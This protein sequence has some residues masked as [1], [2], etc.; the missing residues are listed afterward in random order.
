[1]KTD[2]IPA[3]GKLMPD[4]TP[5][6]T[7]A[8]VKPYGPNPGDDVRQALAT[9]RAEQAFVLHDVQGMTWREVAAF[10]QWSLPTVWD[11]AA[12][13]R[14]FLAAESAAIV[15]DEKRAT[16]REIL[17]RAIAASL[18]IA[19]DASEPAFTRLTA[20]RAVVAAVGQQALID[21]TLARDLPK[22]ATR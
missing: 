18:K 10:M 3:D 17:R 20:A 9:A 22:V 15:L 1:M 14:Q 16:Q 5:V 8:L 13:H 4:G 2:I 21:G 11:A 12:Q 19:E 7:P 6:I